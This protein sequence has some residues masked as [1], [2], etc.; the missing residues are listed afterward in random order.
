VLNE[1]SRLARR[2]PTAELLAQWALEH[3]DA[4]G[5]QATR[6]KVREKANYWA[7]CRRIS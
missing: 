3:L 7:L 6:A 2:N 1:Q 4:A 5:F